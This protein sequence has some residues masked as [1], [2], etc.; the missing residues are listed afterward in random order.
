MCAAGPE[1]M[2]TDAGVAV[3]Q[4]PPW[5]SWRDTALFLSAEAHLLA[6]DVD[7][8]CALFAESSSVAATASNTDCLVLSE[9]E[10]ALVA[11]D[12]GRWER[13]A[14]ASIARSLWSM[15]IGWTTTPPACSSW[16]WRPDSR[17]TAVTRTR[18][19]A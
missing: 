1:Q 6:G 5:S 11:M 18:P 14:T 3:A 12:H 8:A 13:P 19:T 4:E 16:P 9:S 10:L 17:C 2:M 15:N 7:R